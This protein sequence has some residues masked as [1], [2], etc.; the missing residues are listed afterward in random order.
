MLID[1]IFAPKRMIEFRAYVIP[2]SLGRTKNRPLKTLEV[3]W[4]IKL[5]RTQKSSKN[6]I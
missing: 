2:P 3:Y 5:F 4:T 6:G 1:V